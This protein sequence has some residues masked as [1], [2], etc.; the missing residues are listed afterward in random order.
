MKRHVD[1]H[2]IFTPRGITPPWRPGGHVALA[3]G[4]ARYEGV[5]WRARREALAALPGAGIFDPAFHFN[6]DPRRSKASWTQWLR[7]ALAVDGWAMPRHAIMPDHEDRDFRS[8]PA[9]QLRP[10]VPVNGHFYRHSHRQLRGSLARTRHSA[11]VCDLDADGKVLPTGHLHPRTGEVVVP[12][13]GWHDH[14]KHSKYLY[15]PGNSAKRLGTNP[16][17]IERNYEGELFVIVME[18]TLKMVAVTEAGY[19]CIDAGSVTLWASS[20]V[21]AEPDGE[22]GFY[23]GQ[24]LELDEFCERHLEGRSVAVV[25]DSDWHENAAV[26][27]QTETVAG[28][29]GRYAARVVACAPPE[30]SSYGWSH[31]L[32]GIER[33]AK[34]GVDD[35][36]GEHPRRARADAMLDLVFHEPV[37]GAELTADHPA[38]AGIRR[39]ARENTAELVRALGE[40]ASPTERV[41]P[42]AEQSLM[43]SLGRAKRTLQKAR[44]RAVEG[45]LIEEL[46]DAERRSNGEGYYTVPPLV[47][48]VPEA[49][50]IYRERTLRD[51]L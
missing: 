8:R 22:G 46:T 43:A 16:L 33:R 9:T 49:M 15:T 13:D 41:T 29:V 4:F 32:T 11:K 21:E 6:P 27:F 3:Q 14:W 26:R 2:D 40:T 42:Y 31:P 34:R 30:G 28:I 37:G 23:G 50:P 25:C 24:Y 20:S 1:E 18:G 48:V 39:D 45:G 10:D 5:D 36:L 47:R 35:W 44:L 19:P 7:G 17:S 38:L 51:W 12:L